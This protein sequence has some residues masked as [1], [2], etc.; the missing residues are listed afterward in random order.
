MNEQDLDLELVRK[1]QQGDKNAFNLLVAKYQNKVAALISRYVSNS[2]DVADVAQEAFIKAYRALPN[3]RGDSAF[4]TW[5]YRI[6]VNCSKNYLVSQGRKAPASDIDAEEAEVYDGADQL[7]SN[8]SPESLL[9]SDE[10]KA[11]IFKT[12]EELPDDLKTAITLR[13]I[14]GM[15]Y[16]EIAV[17][18][19]CPV[20]TV[21]SR[22]FRAREAIDKNINPL[23]GKD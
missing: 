20:G 17:V 7:R 11:V 3:F 16:E 15:S 21:R 23:I 19:E 12:I 2:G 9:L 14:E 5:L 8:A 22:I 6:A 18:M 13:E 1:V 4:Y 10:I